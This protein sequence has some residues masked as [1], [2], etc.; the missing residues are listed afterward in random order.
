M[1]YYIMYIKTI[2][3]SS[4]MLVTPNSLIQL[5]SSSV[6]GRWLLTECTAAYRDFY[7][8]KPDFISRG[9]PHQKT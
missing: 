1:Y 5:P 8:T 7:C 6:W 4:F 9:A 3:T 2:Q